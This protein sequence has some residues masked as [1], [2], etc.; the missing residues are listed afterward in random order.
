MAEERV[1]VPVL[2]NADSRLFALL[3]NKRNL[4]MKETLFPLHQNTVLTVTESTKRKITTKNRFWIQY[5]RD[6]EVQHL[7]TAMFSR[8]KTNNNDSSS[9]MNYT[10]PNHHDHAAL[11]G[12]QH[13]VVM[14]M[15]CD[16]KHRPPKRR[17]RLKRRVQ[18]VWNGM[19]W[20]ISLA[21]C[22]T[23]RRAVLPSSWLDDDVDTGAGLGMGIGLDIFD[24]QNSGNDDIVMTGAR[25][26][27]TTGSIFSNAAS[28]G[29]F[30]ATSR[31]LL[32]TI[33]HERKVGD[34][35]DE[36]NGL[37]IIDMISI[38]SNTR[39]DYLI[40]QEETFGSHPSVRN[41]YAITEFND[42][43]ADCLEKVDR[44][45]LMLITRMRCRPV[46]RRKIGI[47]ETSYPVL[48]TLSHEFFGFN[49][50]LNEKKNPI[51][52]LCA[53]KRPMDGLYKVLTQYSHD[54]P[55]LPDYLIM[56]DDDSW[57]NM[58]LL[59]PALKAKINPLTPTAVAGCLISLHYPGI[60][61][62]KFRYPWGGFGT[63]INRATIINL[64]RPI[65]CD[66]QDRELCDW[67]AQDRLMELEI[68]EH[69][70]TMSL[71]EL[72]YRYTFSQ[73]YSEAENWK[74][75][76]CFHSDSKCSQ[77]RVKQRSKGNY[78]SYVLVTSHGRI[79]RDFLSF[80]SFLPTHA[81][82]LA[83]F[84]MYA[85]KDEWTITFPN[86]TLGFQGGVN[87]KGWQMDGGQCLNKEVE[88]DENDILCHY[89]SPQQMQMVHN[90]I[91]I[92]RQQPTA[93]LS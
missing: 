91:V 86:S 62:T 16:L 50:L 65:Q 75:G 40:A 69:D 44:H 13:T 74:V 19:P 70:R 57:F 7:Y 51:G 41:F 8:Q 18:A 27:A 38:G 64:L 82:V 45:L 61:D 48:F 21:L 79:A 85:T 10:R 32:Q 93:A 76:Y 83:Y 34:N 58:D 33:T 12:Q 15:G 49:R 3:E 26:T 71:L 89:I 11:R 68:F 63:I 39:P 23:L 66:G 2:K 67:I 14:A 73:P 52:W 42:T 5:R 54:S 84:L 25:V 72:M 78:L 31:S 81:V 17:K 55:D 4:G 24:S 92:D 30:S 22:Y 87:P 1:I 90:R 29:I 6:G 88:C 37:P 20:I 47:N 43:E 60:G 36:T 56:M 46:A 9:N 59:L 28:E 35:G 77:Y 53:Q 80:L